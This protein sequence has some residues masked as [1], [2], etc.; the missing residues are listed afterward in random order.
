MRS[1]RRTR[2]GMLTHPRVLTYAVTFR[3]NARCV[4]CDSWKKP[5]EDEL[6]LDE[7]LFIFDGLPTM[8]LVR[9]TGGEPFLRRDLLDIAGAAQ[10]RLRPLALH[11][12]TNGFLT[13]RIVAFCEDRA[14]N[15]PLYLLISVDGLE[16]KH[17]QVRGRPDAWER[18]VGTISALA[19]RRRALRLRLGVNQTIGDAAGLDDYERVR[20]F[21]RPYGL[22]SNVVLAY[23]S[24]ATYCAETEAVVPPPDFSR[25]VGR[26]LSDAGRAE[27][28]FHTVERDLGRSS[29]PERVGKRYYIRG[30]KNR[31]LNRSHTPNPRCVA[32][33]S[34]IRLLPDGSVPTCQF[35]TTRVGSLRHQSLGAI[36]GGDAMQRQRAWVQGCPGCWAECE[37][38]PNAVYSGDLFRQW[39]RRDTRAKRM[40]GL[41]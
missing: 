39:F 4:M 14:K 16:E 27:R 1:V 22:R 3:C 6:S 7:I 5:A 18:V 2:K 29:L 28:F 24:S 38:L 8:D 40:R 21:L 12:T 34:H 9:L 13:D 41:T 26:C 25:F 15:V 23:D 32:L 35:N 11:I 30:L 36:C 17:N 20:D 37:V 33:G 31:V 19:P 10:E